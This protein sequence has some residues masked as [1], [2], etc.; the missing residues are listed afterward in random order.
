MENKQKTATLAGFLDEV[1]KIADAAVAMEALGIPGALWEGHHKGGLKGMATTGLGA[2]GGLGAGM[3]ASHYVKKLTGGQWGANHPILK[4][5]AEAAPVGM[6]GVI[7]GALGS[8]FTRPMPKL[9]YITK[10][11]SLAT[12]LLLKSV[13]N[14]PI[15][16]SEKRNIDH[17]PERLERVEYAIKNNIP[18]GLV[19]LP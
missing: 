15:A 2:V 7:G 9:G 17:L 13:K 11:A 3:L 5:I 8:H 6:G 16:I 14:A 18:M 1:E 10:E 19:P 12:S 4:T